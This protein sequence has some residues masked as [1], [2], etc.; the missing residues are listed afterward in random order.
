MKASHYKKYIITLLL[1]TTGMT[2]LAQDLTGYWVGV[3]NT[4]MDFSGKRRSFR[5]KMELEQ[6]GKKVKGIFSNALMDFPDDPQVIYTISG[7]AGRK[8]NVPISLIAGT[9][10]KSTLPF[11][12]AAVFLQFDDILYTKTDTAE[13]LSGKWLPNGARTP[14]PDGAG[15]TFWV[16]RIFGAPKTDTAAAIKPFAQ[17]KKAVLDTLSCTTSTLV[18][19]MYDNGVVDGDSISVYVNDAPVLQRQLITA[20]PVT[21][22]LP[23]EK[24][25]QYL[26]SLFAEN[27]GRIPP[28]TALLKIEGGGLMKEILLSSSFDINAS[29]L[30][31]VE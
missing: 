18:L 29:V 25:K 2:A 28:N 4:D 8:D 9:L 24:G 12:Q 19:S 26:I 5:L 10:I 3:F 6:N 22:S 13:Y 30:I 17:R 16:R 31:K 1:I 14:R 20:K 23:V 11:E 21:I 15:G 7:K 27:L